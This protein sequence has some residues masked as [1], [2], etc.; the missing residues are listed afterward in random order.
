MLLCVKYS[1]SIEPLSIR[2]PDK[3]PANLVRFLHCARRTIPIY[4]NYIGLAPYKESENSTI[5][6]FPL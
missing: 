2:F 6:R 4:H 3:A 5:T 1:P